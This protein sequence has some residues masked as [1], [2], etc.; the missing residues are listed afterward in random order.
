MKNDVFKYLLLLFLLSIVYGCYDEGRLLEISLPSREPGLVIHSLVYPS[1]GLERPYPLG[2]KVSSTAHL[3]DKSPVFITDAEVLLYKN[4]H[5]TERLAYVDSLGYYPFF[6]SPDYN[7][8]YQV[9]VIK[10]GFPPT[11]A[12]TV[13]PSAIEIDTVI[14]TPFAY[15]DEEGYVFS[16]V[17]IRF[18]DAP[19]ETNFYEVVVFNTS[20]FY[21][22]KT[23]F[24]P[25]DYQEN[26]GEALELVAFDKVIT[27]EPYYTSKT[28]IN[29]D[30]P[31]SL[32]F[33]DN[34]FNGQDYS[35]KVYFN[36]PG[37][38]H[39]AGHIANHGA[40][41]YLRNVTEETF[42]FKTSMIQ[43]YIH[44]QED[45]L[46]GVGEPVNV[47]SNIE[48][49]YGLFGAYSYDSALLLIDEVIVK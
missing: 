11:M 25:G 34:T 39:T 5:L 21:Q 38:I 32:L 45:I 26:T 2:I 23:D 36:P 24:R 1:S 35:L 22:L 9:E 16:E 15:F 41:V 30:Y 49:G 42:E 31:E 8:G 33:R 19:G 28:D 40:R 44:R 14:I 48:N 13:V 6:E 37:R 43:H 20:G 46:Y 29:S 47:F 4:G 3:Y 7:D 27:E 17:E 10:E 18:Q 12:S